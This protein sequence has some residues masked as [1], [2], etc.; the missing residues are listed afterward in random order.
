MAM[1][2]R[3]STNR[4]LMLMVILSCFLLLTVMADDDAPSTVVDDVPASTPTDETDAAVATPTQSAPTPA[5]ECPMTC[6]N[7]GT[8]KV[9]EADYSAFP[10]E[11]NG[12]SLTFLRETTREGWHCECPLSWTGVRCEIGAKDDPANP[13]HMCFHGGKCIGGMEDSDNVSAE[14]RFCDCTDAEHNGVPY[15]GKYCEIKG[16]VECAPGSDV[17]CVADGQCKDDFETKA[18]PCKC[19]SGHRGPHC[20]FLRD[21]VPECTKECKNGGECTLGVKDYE[22]ARYQEF[23]L[24]HDENY[25]YCVSA[26]ITFSSKQKDAGK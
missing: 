2:S 10:N 11:A 25:Q 22:T 26:S 4:H 19:N 12:I 5:P 17:F 15:F 6:S 8:C 21:E 1:L 20:E 13:I 9:G 3:R 16:A 7:G 18:H 23:W 24:T 14:Q